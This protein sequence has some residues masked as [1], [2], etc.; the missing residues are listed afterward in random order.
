MEVIEF[1]GTSVVDLLDA[2]S[3][4]TDLRIFDT[5][6]ADV[7]TLG[8]GSAR[9][10][11]NSF[12]Q[13]ATGDTVNNFGFDDVIDFSEFANGFAAPI[14]IGNAAFSGLANEVRYEVF[15]TFTEVQ[16]DID[17]DGVADRSVILNG[18]GIELTEASQGSLLIT[19]SATNI[20]TG[21]VTNDNLTGTD[22]ADTING[23]DGNDLLIG[24]GGDDIL[25]GGSGNDTIYTGTGNNTIDGGDGRDFLTYS[26]SA[27]F[28]PA[29]GLLGAMTVTITDTS[30]FIAET[31]RTD[32][33]SNVE[34]LQVFAT[35]FVG[36]T[37]ITSVSL[38]ASAVTDSSIFVNLGG[39]SG[40]D[41][42][43]GGAGSD[44]LQGSGGNDI[45]SGGAGNDRIFN[46]SG[47]N[48]IDGQDG[49]DT[50]GVD[51]FGFRTAESATTFVGWSLT[52]TFVFD[53]E[54]SSFTTFANIEA[55]EFRG[56]EVI[57][58]LDASTVTTS[59][60]ITDT[61]GAD[62][63]TLGTGPTLLRFLAFN[64][65]ATGDQINGFKSGDVIDLSGLAGT[66]AR[67]DFIG[68]SAFSGTRNEVRYEVFDTF[69]E[70]QIDID[71]DGI[72]DRSII[73]QGTGLF[74]NET[75]SGSL[76]LSLRAGNPVPGASGDD[77]LTGTEGD[78]LINA[79]AGNDTIETLGGNDL[80][81]AG[82]G[83]DTINVGSGQ[84]D[85]YAGAGDDLIVHD[86]PRHR[87][88]VRRRGF[89]ILRTD[90]FSIR[91]RLQP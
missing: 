73:L 88:G 21:T 74:L 25:N 55:L 33:F 75:A 67:P 52:D 71:A 22:R 6:G 41:T 35:N 17:A 10:Q 1:E 14:F 34:V 61:D 5:D 77:V 50:V 63:Y 16:I 90:P 57:D 70:V 45:I 15:D 39:T 40:N 43:I 13:S 9:V 54:T 32:T 30:L 91:R 11:F 79:L 89:D 87:S 12:F 38:D 72:A 85:I 82:T 68:V 60:L 36:D 29:F 3:L 76:Q 81:L 80:V 66:A 53:S 23:L 48:T 46:F 58:L 49:F 86:E 64:E 2:S 51:G 62:S 69:T 28:G 47:S 31:S 26:S 78:D 84:N 20:I 4:A 44:W 24:L 19:R 65:A 56:T 7:Y 8:T 42:I 83:N 18:A 37:D 59:L 27:Q